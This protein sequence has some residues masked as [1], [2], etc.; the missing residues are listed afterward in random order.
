MTKFFAAIGD[1]RLTSL[2]VHVPNAGAWF[3]DI[4][5]DDVAS[6]GARPFCWAPHLPLR[7]ALIRRRLKAIASRAMPARRLRGPV[8]LRSRQ[9][10]PPIRQVARQALG[11]RWRLKH[12]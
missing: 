6:T 11:E 10:V 4:D 1:R 12:G 2:K 8:G 5:V 3:A 9:K 7:P